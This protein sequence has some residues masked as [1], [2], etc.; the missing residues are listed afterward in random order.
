MAASASS[1]NHLGDAMNRRRLDLGLRWE[2][3]AESAGISVTGLRLL[4]TTGG[5]PRELTQRGLEKALAWEPGSIRAILDGGDP[6]PVTGSPGGAA[7]ADDRPVLVRSAWA[8]ET[9]RK[10]WALDLVDPG[11]RT[12]LVELYLRRNAEQ[13]S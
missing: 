3:V 12:A 11:T 10:I 6:V 1:R 4:R 9:V 7:P 5:T 13:A 8:D 2:V